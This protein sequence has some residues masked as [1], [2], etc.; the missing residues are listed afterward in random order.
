MINIRNSS[1][2]AGLALLFSP[3]LAQAN[4]GHFMVDRAVK[5]RAQGR[6]QASAWV[7]SH[8]V[9]C[10][11]LRVRLNLQ[12]RASCNSRTACSE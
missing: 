6:G 12:L 8:A 9:R 5:G 11:P 3:V 7:Q 10:Q 2:A 1:F 4:N